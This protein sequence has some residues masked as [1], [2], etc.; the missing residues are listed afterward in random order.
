[1]QFESLTTW[2]KHTLHKIL[3]QYFWRYFVVMTLLVLELMRQWLIIYGYEPQSLLM[4]RL[5]TIEVNLELECLFTNLYPCQMLANSH[6][7]HK[8]NIG[9][10]ICDINN[11][12]S[13][14]TNSISQKH[15]SWPVT[16]WQGTR[17]PIFKCQSKNSGNTSF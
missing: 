2:K 1:M 16:N 17:K 6:S 11:N 15:L 14:E 3:N 12:S 8:E 10:K 5:I 7:V 13:Q 9:T 4:Q